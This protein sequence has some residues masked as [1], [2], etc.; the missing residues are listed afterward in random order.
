MPK[1]SEEAVSASL[2]ELA[3][4]TETAGDEVVEKVIEKRDA[5]HPRTFIGP[6][7]AEALGNLASS[8]G[9]EIIILNDSLSPSQQRSL[10]EV[11]GKGIIDRTGL[12]LDIFARH[13][14]S[15]DGSLQ[16]ELAQSEYRLPRLRGK[17][18]ELSRLGGGIGTKGPGEMKLEVD[19]RRIQSR[20]R[21]LKKELERIARTR[22]TQTK[23]RRKSG[24]FEVCLVGYT[25]AG[26][27]TLLNR[28]TGAD[29]YV[30]DMLFA[31]LD[32]TTRRL[33]APGRDIV[34]SDTV[35]FIKD[36]PHEL[37]AAFRATLEGVRNADLLLEIVDVADPGWPGHLQSVE[38]VLKEIGAGEK[39]AVLVFNKTDKAD[40][41]ELARLKR[42][43]Y[44]AVLVS[45]VTAAGINGLVSLLREKA[46]EE[47]AVHRLL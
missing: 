10:E 47:R 11:T 43:Y 9:A 42:E 1:Q 16:V 12:I 17:G 40:V 30:A 2:E 34:I 37:I 21:R 6:G 18:V 20:I 23:R 14:V 15:K 28:L 7:Q 24:V 41:N 29:A 32:S 8:L 46:A 4:L 22:E 26:K 44:D 27:T 25:N 35:G 39:P 13:A 36:L 45:V 19:R 5:I 33:S 38:E 3:R 31:T